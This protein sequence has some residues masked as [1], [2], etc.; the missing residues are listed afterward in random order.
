MAGIKRIKPI[1]KVCTSYTIEFDQVAGKMFVYHSALN[2][3]I[4]IFL[5]YVLCL[6]R[7]AAI[8]N[9]LLVHGVEITPFN[10]TRCKSGSLKFRYHSLVGIHNKAFG[11]RDPVA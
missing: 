10:P 1:E 6:L 11:I 2:A 3:A 7:M 5:Q 9:I 4:E 8:A